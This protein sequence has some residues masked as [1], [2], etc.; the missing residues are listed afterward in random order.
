[1]FKKIKIAVL[2]AITLLAISDIAFAS[3]R[4]RGGDRYYRP[5]LRHSDCRPNYHYRRAIIAPPQRGPVA[6]YPSWG[7]IISPFI[8]IG[9]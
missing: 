3:G 8:V 6:V 7:I 1:M 2:A 5:E 4:Q 9:F